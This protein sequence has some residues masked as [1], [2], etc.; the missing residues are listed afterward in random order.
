MNE[1]QKMAWFNKMLED[2]DVRAQMAKRILKEYDSNK[3]NKIDV[4]ELEKFFED[5]IKRGIWS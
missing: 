5:G 4:S 1:S 2:K 3:D